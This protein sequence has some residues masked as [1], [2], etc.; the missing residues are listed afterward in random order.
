[1]A[2]INGEL[3]H[4]GRIV[5]S[6]TVEAVTENSVTL[7]GLDGH[8]KTFIIVERLLSGSISFEKQAR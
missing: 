4:Q 1:M 5:P 2:L 8:I 7:L 6:Q 3:H